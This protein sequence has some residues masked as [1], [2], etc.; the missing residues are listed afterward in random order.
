MSLFG[1]TKNPEK[2]NVRIRPAPY[3]YGRTASLSLRGQRL[4]RCENSVRLPRHSPDNGAET[5]CIST[6]SSP[7][8]YFVG[9][10][11]KCVY[12]YICTPWT[13]MAPK[14]RPS[15]KETRIL[16]SGRVPL[17][18]PSNLI[19]IHQP[20][21]IHEI[22][23]DFSTFADMADQHFNLCK[24]PTRTATSSQHLWFLL[25]DVLNIRSTNF[26]LINSLHLPTFLNNF[27]SHSFTSSTLQSW[28]CATRKMLSKRL[29]PMFWKANIPKPKAHNRGLENHSMPRERWV[30]TTDVSRENVVFC[31]TPG[32]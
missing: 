3:R 28:S 9:C 16:V 7:F 13:N 15:Q 10:R 29:F 19:R 21:C 24:S 20:A 17:F 1:M 5:S 25:K 22:S 27:Q 11:L 26:E 32:C 6:K 23:N 8:V 4:E 31:F 18:F 14:N 30:W 2:K 12:I